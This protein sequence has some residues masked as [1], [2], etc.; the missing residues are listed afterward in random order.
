MQVHV[1]A[2]VGANFVNTLLKAVAKY[3]HV[4]G[5]KEMPSYS[6]GSDPGTFH[7]DAQPIAWEINLYS[8]YL[9]SGIFVE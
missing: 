3:A 4:L 6:L 8:R 2:P 7:G 9:I 1:S 5:L